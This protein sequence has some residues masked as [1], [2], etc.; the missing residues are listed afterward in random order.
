MDRYQTLAYQLVAMVRGA[1]APHDQH[2]AV[3]KA[4]SMLREE[5]AWWR[6]DDAI[7]AAIDIGSLV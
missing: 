4:A 7:R 3:E 2:A 5:F 6:E 1:D